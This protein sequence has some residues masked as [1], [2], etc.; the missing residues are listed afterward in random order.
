MAN[1]LY[2]PEG[3]RRVKPYAYTDRTDIE[4]LVFP[5]SVHNIGDWAFK[6]CTNLKKITFTNTLTAIGSVAFAECTSLETIE[7]PPN[8]KTI[9]ALAFKGCTKLDHVVI[10]ES[11]TD[12]KGWAFEGCTSLSEIRFPKDL[13]SL[14]YGVLKDCTALKHVELPEHLQTI[15][16]RAFD[17]CT[18]LTTLVIPESVDGIRRGAFYGCINLTDVTIPETVDSIANAPFGYC[19]ALRSV[20]LPEG[21]R[22]LDGT[23]NQCTSLTEVNIP[24][25]VT[26]LSGSTFAKCTS[27]TRIDIPDGV[28]YIGPFC[29]EK[30]PLTEVR[31]P[32]RLHQI[33]RYAFNGGFYGRMVVP[34][35]VISIGERA[36]YSDSL[37]VLDLPSTLLSVG[38][39]MLGDNSQHH[40]DSVIL[41]AMV[42]PYSYN[43][44]LI[45]RDRPTTLYVPQASVSLYQA[46]ADYNQIE[47]IKPLDIGQSHLNIIGKVVVSPSSGLQQAKYDVDMITLHDIAGIEQS[48]NHHP[49]LTV[50][51]GATMRIG[52]LGMTFDAH[53]DWS[54]RQSKYD[55]FI[56][57]G[58]TTIDDIDLRCIF[59]GKYFFTPPF[60]VRVSDIIGDNPNTPVTFYRYDGAAR[61]ATDFDRTWVRL[62]PGETLH[63]GTAYAVLPEQQL[64]QDYTG[65]WGYHWGYYHLKPAAGGVNHFTTSDDI[66]VPLQ[67]HASEFPHNRN[68]NLVGMPFPSFLDIRGLDY[69]GPFFIQG[70]LWKAV[71]ALDD[72]IVLYPH[73]AIFVQCPD[74]VSALTFSADRRQVDDT[75]VKGDAPANS[76]RALRRT[77]QNRHRTVYNLTVEPTPDPSPREG[78]STRFV[79]NPATTTG[80]DLGHDAPLLS[81]DDDNPATLLYTTDASGLAY[82]IN[83][84]PLAD[85][86]IPLGMRLAEG[87]T[88]TL[89][90][91]I[92]ASPAVGGFPAD[93]PVW[94]IDNETG[95]R[96]NL[97]GEESG[98][99]LYT[100]TAS[101]GSHPQ[102]FVIALGDAE[103]TGVSLTQNSELRTQNCFNLL[104]QPVTTPARGVYIKDG[105]KIIK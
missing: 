81:D 70:N 45:S 73:E 68:W 104:G 50:S 105:R 58:T 82:A 49:S 47:S 94:L 23:F 97:L 29:F 9:G 42:P 20:R 93:T 33:G 103:P 76:A 69:D 52:H 62:Q 12:L 40:P 19:S 92:K 26:C 102:R 75:F 6:G 3:T 24:R 48:S 77:D 84:R 100:F 67:H 51:E 95:A 1:V 5:E 10:P 43:E 54:Y 31:L 61:A 39:C 99:G 44:F 8:L 28:T 4:E 65:K 11:V 2:V 64:Y 37:R 101:A 22:T 36:F 88:Y 80:Y 59:T 78:G 15:K 96:T 56:N 27:L 98:V 83:E 21:I 18:G 25:S 66:S 32:S 55:C 90:L 35:G 86:I 30:V 7:F 34:E 74:A 85:G 46:N 63:P 91:R 87:G 72:E 13:P 16:E 41:R 79:I 57:R 17:G 38:G 89:T 53:T 71:S 60:D 14:E